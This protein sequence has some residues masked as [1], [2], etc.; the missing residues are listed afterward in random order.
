MKPR[1]SRRAAALLGAIALVALMVR[2]A[3]ATAQPDFTASGGAISAVKVATV[4]GEQQYGETN[5][6]TDVSGATVA[7]TIP[8]TW[9]SALIASR[10]SAPTFCS[11]QCSIQITMD[12]QVA[13]PGPTPFANNSGTPVADSLDGF[14]VLGPGSH[15]V[16]VQEM[17]SPLT[18][19][20]WTLSVERVNPL[21]P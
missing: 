2:T 10:F 5:N 1:N 7:I 17:G 14:L 9:R 16:K 6:W 20:N 3:L 19:Y 11:V 12:G 15:T 21:T 4:D 13:H 8:S 18:F